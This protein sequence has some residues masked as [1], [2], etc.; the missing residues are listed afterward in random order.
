MTPPTAAP[1]KRPS[2]TRAPNRAQ[3]S[4]RSGRTASSP[5]PSARRPSPSRR[6]A[7]PR[8]PQA[9]SGVAKK[10]T[11]T[12]IKP[13][14]RFLK[15]FLAVVLALVCVRLVELQL[16]RA[17]QYQASAASQ[18][19]QTVTIPA[20]R[21]GI[22][23]RNGAVLA[24]SV[25]TKEVIADDFQ[26]THPATEAAAL[27]PLLGTTTANLTPLLER[28]SGYV[29]LAK[30][31]RQGAAATI[32]KDNFPGL[33]MLNTSVRS[34][35]NKAL[36]AS[37]VGVTNA[38]GAGAAGVEYE[39]QH[40]LAGMPGVET[41][42]ETPYGVS[43]PQGGVVH[44]ADGT[45]G[46]GLELTLDQP[47][48]YVTEQALASEIVSSH[49]ISGTAIVMDVHTGQI[50]SMANLVSTAPN[51][52]VV[53]TPQ[54]G[55]S[56]PGTPGV[57]QAANNLAVTQTYEPG[58]VFKLVP[59]SAALDEGLINP[60]TVFQVPDRV[61]VDTK[62][63]H[64]AETH[65]VEALTAT[66]ILAQS[67]NIGTYEIA[68]NLGESR[69]LAQVEKLGF[70]QY[71]GLKFPGESRGLL[72]NAGLWEPTDIASLPIG[73]VDA[74]TPLQ[75]LDAYNSVANGGTFVNPQLVRA[76]VGSNGQLI[77]APASS[78]RRVMSSTTAS[79]LTTML[80]QVVT[81]GTGV[82]AAI[83]GYLVA[84]K[85]GTSQIPTP[86]QASYVDG[87]YNATFVGF[88]PAN[89]PVLSALV[90]LERPTGD[91]FGGGVAAP[92]FA[93]IMSY[94]LHRYG[95][96]TSPGG[97]GPQVPTTSSTAV[98]EST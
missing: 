53:Q 6:P 55:A 27:A 86:G 92:V 35:P 30:H 29:I 46:K 91:Y 4:G 32:A 43:L 11:G 31:L 3:P 65:A 15:V 94:A 59:F 34:V 83:P 28:H 7:D 67:S 82:E 54:A 23:D 44:S 78:A 96:P 19:R 24:M 18:L 98:Q 17:S 72:M 45:P 75:V 85:T 49:A 16:F 14:L 50:L 25:P 77:S 51:N 58:S 71:S 20:L 57:A 40:E 39:F 73:Q 90:V 22:Y 81:T 47:L 48:Q 37:V 10:A 12:L 97:N 68:N 21:G 80:Q 1:P 63:F 87:S 52:G 84:G 2:A 42:L 36:A 95:I 69:L 89:H 64:D 5:R 66:Q 62:T 56:M 8:R 38:S 79:E 13:R 60:T 33:T 74:A 93:R 76:T 70:G 88:A 61:T 9:R 26:I 41:L